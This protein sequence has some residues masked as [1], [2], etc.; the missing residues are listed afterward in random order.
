M[1]RSSINTLLKR[2]SLVHDMEIK[3]VNFGRSTSRRFL[4][5]EQDLRGYTDPRKQAM[6]DEISMY[7]KDDLLNTPTEKLAQYF[8]DKYTFPFIEIDESG[9]TV[10]E[11]E[12][13][14]DVSQNPGYMVTNTS[15]PFYV[16]GT[17]ITITIPYTGRREILS[18]N[19]NQAWMASPIE[20]HADAQQIVFSIS[21]L[22]QNTGDFKAEIDGRIRIIKER[23]DMMRDDVNQYNSSLLGDAT[24][25]IDGRK[26]K[27]QENSSILTSLGFKTERRDDT[28][29]TYAVP[30][31]KRDV[32]PPRPQATEAAKDREPILHIEE[33]EHI[34]DVISNMVTVMEQSPKAFVDMDEETIRTHFLVQLNGQY[35]GQATGETFNGDGKTDIIIKS[36]GKN[37]FIAECKF[38]GGEEIFKSALKQLLGYATWRDGKIALLVFNRNKNTTAVLEKIR[39]LVEADDNFVSFDGQPSETDFRFTLF[40]PTDKDKH[41][42]LAVRVYDIP[43]DGGTHD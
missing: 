10:N 23:L 8:S 42:T 25:A 38:W 4:F 28:A 14:I 15:R 20:A 1:E 7:D 27:L 31:V 11:Q 16:D 17:E 2:V 13:K 29:K 37:V 36:D 22:P 32:Q 40:H 18:S 30:N 41:L 39:P 26:A 6:L 12:A 19:P 24:Q 3:I 35:K 5:N 21:K 9:I 34:L 43:I 33:F